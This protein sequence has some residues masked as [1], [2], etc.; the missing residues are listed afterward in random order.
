MGTVLLQPSMERSVSACRKG[1]QP[2]ELGTAG[3]VTG[4]ALIVSDSSHFIS[5]VLELCG[6]SNC[7][8]D[9][10]VRAQH[11]KKGAILWAG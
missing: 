5:L 10:L 3:K 2:I 1:V 7:D 9:S 8:D 6:I 4:K 11:F